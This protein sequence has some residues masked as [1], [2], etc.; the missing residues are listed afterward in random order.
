[1]YAMSRTWSEDV[2][3]GVEGGDAYGGG[4]LAPEFRAWNSHVLVVLSRVAVA[5]ES[6]GKT[7]KEF[8]SGALEHV[9]GVFGKREEG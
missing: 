4:A 7:A 6:L 8:P 3:S 2:S 9:R 1:M 5:C